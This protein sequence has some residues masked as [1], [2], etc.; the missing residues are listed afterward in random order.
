MYRSDEVDE[1]FPNNVA[2]GASRPMLSSA[3]L[4][5]YA[6][7]H[8]SRLNIGESPRNSTEQCKQSLYLSLL[9]K[10]LFIYQLQCYL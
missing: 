3:F 1:T 10:I 9:Y 4:C 2:S 7:R 5:D 6:M 8:R